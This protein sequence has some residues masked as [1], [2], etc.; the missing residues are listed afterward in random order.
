LEEL[1][2]IEAHTFTKGLT[3]DYND[4]LQ[5]EDTVTFARNAIVFSH[6]GDMLYYQNEPST[7]LCCELPKD[8]DIIGD[9]KLPDGTRILFLTNDIES[10]IGIFDEKLCTYK[11]VAKNSCWN[12][13][14]ANL[15]TARTKENSDCTYSVYWSD[16]RRNPD[17]FLNLSKIP[18]KYTLEPNPNGGCDIK[19]YTT[20]IDCDATLL[21]KKID[22]PT[23]SI[24]KNIGGG[25]LENAS[26]QAIIA[27][28]INGLR[29][30][31][32]YGLTNPVSI[33]NKQNNTGSLQ[34]KIDKNSFD[35]D[36]EEFELVV[37]QTLNSSTVAK[38]IGIYN[39]NTESIFVSN[40][41]SAQ[42]KAILIENIVTQNKVYE[43]SDQISGNQEYLFRIGT[44]SPYELNYQPQAFD[45]TAKY[46]VKQVSYDYYL[47]NNTPTY[48]R[49]EV[50]RLYIQWYHE[51]GYWSSL[52]HISNR[53]AKP[54]DLAIATGDDV[55]ELDE[56]I[57]QPK[58]YFEI[59]NTS[60]SPIL[61]N[62]E[63]KGEFGYH[64]STDEYPNN[65]FTHG[66]NACKPIRDFKF[67][68]EEQI[69]RIEI[70]NGKQVINI[71]GIELD[72]IQP[73]T[74]KGWKGYRIIRADRQ[75]HR[76]IISRGFTTNVRG[77]YDNE[78]QT[79]TLYN[80][81]PN[82]DLRPD[83]FH[84]NTQTVYKKNSEQ[85]Y[86]PLTQVYNNKF[87]FN[88]P[89]IDYYNINPGNILTIESEEIGNCEGQFVEV[90][91]HPKFTLLS[92]FA[93]WVAASLG[94][95]EG[96]L[97]LSGKTVIKAGGKI[98]T[99]GSQTGAPLDKTNDYQEEVSIKSAQ[100]L[101]GVDITALIAA[102]IKAGKTENILKTIKLAFLTLAST[103][104][105]ALTFGLWAIAYADQILDIIYKAVGGKAKNQYVYQYNAKTLFKNT[106]AKTFNGFK[107]RKII[108]YQKIGDNLT[109]INDEVF[110]NRGGNNTLY[111]ELNKDLKPTDNIDTSRNT[112][113]ELGICGQLNQINKT[114]AVVYYATTSRYIPN[115]YGQIDSYINPIQTHEGIY[116]TTKTPVIFGGD[117]YITPYSKSIKH[118]IFEQSAEGFGNK[119][120]FE[121]DYR[122]Y[123]NNGFPRFWLNSFKYDFAEVLN[124]KIVNNTTFSRNTK[125]RYNLDCKGRDKTNV[126]TVDDAYM[127]KGVYNAIE[128]LVESDYN[129]W[130]REQDTKDD[131]FYHDNSTKDINQLFRADRLRKPELFKYNLTYSKQPNEIYGRQLDIN[132][133]PNVYNKC[134]HYE[135]NRLIYSMPQFRENNSDN[136][137]LYLSGNTYLFPQADF[138]AI[139]SVSKLDLDR[140]LFLF[141]KAGPFETVGQD[142]LSLDESG[143][144]ITIGDGGLFAQKPREKISTEH[145]Y[146]NSQSKFSTITTQF[147]TFYPSERQG[148]F[149]NYQNQPDEIS[150]KGIHLWAKQF[151]PIK[152]LEVFPE[153]K[154]NDNVAIGVGYQIAFDSTWDMLYYIKKD[155]AP[156]NKWKN[157]ITYNVKEDKFYVDNN[158]NY[159]IKLTDKEYFD[160]LSFTLSYYCPIQQFVS[161]HDWNPKWIINSEKHFMSF[162]D[163]KIWKHN[164]NCKS[165]CTYY[166]KPY[167]FEIEFVQSN[168]FAVNK[169]T[170]ATWYLECFKYINDNCKD[171]N[172]QQFANFDTM[173]VYNTEQCSP[174]MNLVTKS[175]N[176]YELFPR[177]NSTGW[178]ISCTKVENKYNVNEFADANKNRKLDLNLINFDNNGWKR[179]I[180]R[181][182][183]D[184][185][186]SMQNKQLF[187]H[188]D[189]RVLLTKNE[190]NDL[191][192]IF[193]LFLSGQIKSPR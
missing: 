193:K 31:S 7:V 50:Y 172:H 33:F 17:R 124:K 35:N 44:Q 108:N 105:K 99:P 53:K 187:R 82:N 181:N 178:D 81:Y 64:E 36:F 102:P 100:D 37:L 171:K 185:S 125:S 30:S 54:S 28:T 86:S 179:L 41:E 103:G 122:L 83:T 114:Q 79:Q 160:D 18:Y 126:F 128:L 115:Q 22:F 183:I 55:F 176:P 104:L 26:Y 164:D 133:D 123:R 127:Y 48:Y 163:G 184:I 85:N 119:D 87:S 16:S 32:Y 174:L 52:S 88:S 70:I 161:F 131:Y 11:K 169:F 68:S 84:S 63:L 158:Y 76:S 129:L 15:I 71:L 117:C 90:Y 51:L 59:H 146:G 43:S 47:E 34:V 143:R 153:Y 6:E 109:Q 149:F 192:M 167:P 137:Q 96:L 190:S 95:L 188:Y 89:H 175:K 20:E 21:S 107:R 46:V 155:Y 24:E 8:F 150:R 154:H 152:L 145:N 118:D 189:T 177:T 139:T 132:Y 5:K 147:G 144:K 157:K 162:Q 120:G 29:Y 142:T 134:Y 67:P 1:K 168:Q 186:T 2:K 98:Q 148:R 92:T 12:F 91:Q 110:V 78:T 151:I 106:I 97:V 173:V 130:Y 65:I 61:I 38:K 116:K 56:R 60:K 159:E 74:E 156:N 77:Y 40:F 121:F 25:V 23:V 140:V 75:G 141:D 45:I 113:S 182:A 49:N 27:F 58:R 136:W 166:D 112:I 72:N 73:P 69:P 62:G 111:I 101:I 3:I 42:Y 39:R 93:F 19:K 4:S 57:P 135:P 14:K 138:G 10:E 9:E 170:N 191:K 180:N 94:I 66:E 13:N 80:N 165:Y